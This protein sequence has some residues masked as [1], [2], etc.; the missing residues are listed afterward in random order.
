MSLSWL[1]ELEKELEEKFSNFL[2][3]NPYQEKIFIKQREK[4]RYAYLELE[5]QQVQDKAK[6]LR[7]E[8]LELAKDIKEWSKRSKRANKAG[9]KDLAKKADNHIQKLM[10]HGRNLWSE[11][12]HLGC[13]FREL[14]KEVLEINTQEIAAQSQ[15]EKEW[16]QLETDE[17]LKRLKRE[18][19]LN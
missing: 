15:R 14:D 5:K 6:S 18:K 1:D 10:S 13:K 3:A 12:D 9:A 11:L 17:E 4:D 16:A 8:L 7:N 2:Q 19:G